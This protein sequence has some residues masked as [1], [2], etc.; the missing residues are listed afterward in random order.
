[1]RRLLLCLLVAVLAVSTAPAAHA[2]VPP[3]TPTYQLGWGSTGTAPGQFDSPWGG[4][5]DSLGNVYIVDRHNLRVEKFNS[6]GDFVMSLNGMALPL[7]VAVSNGVVYVADNSWIKEFDS[8]GN[9]ILQFGSPGSGNGQFSFA[10]GIAV[11]R[12]G[13]MYVADYYLMRV[14]KFTAGGGYVSQW[15]SAGSGNGQFNN[16]TG[17]CCDAS[18][19]VYVVDQSNHRVQEFTSS[20]VYVT[21]WGTHGSANGQFAF[22]SGIAVDALGN[23]YVTDEGNG[24]VQKF[25]PS[26]AYVTQF[27]SV[28]SANG[29]FVTPAG[30]AVDPAG[31]V[32]VSDTGNDRLQK[33][34][35]A[36]VGLPTVHWRDWP[37][38]S[39]NYS[40]PSCAM[41]AASNLYVF[42]YSGIRKY[43]FSGLNSSLIWQKNTYDIPLDPNP[44]PFYD[45]AGIAV[46]RSGNIYVTE[47]GTQGAPVVKFD[48]A[49]NYVARW[50]SWGS[51]NGEFSFPSGIAADGSGNVYVVDQYQRRVQKFSSDGTYLLQ[52]GTMGS[53]NG[54]FDSPMGIATD[55]GGNVYVG[56]PHLNTTRQGSIQ[57]FSAAGTYVGQWPADGSAL[58]IDALG[59]VFSNGAVYTTNGVQMG[60]WDDPAAPLCVTSDP[61][62]NVYFV[63]QRDAHVHTLWPARTI[64]LVSDVG[65]DQGHQARVRFPR[66]IYDNAAAW[67]KAYDVYSVLDTSTAVGSVQNTGYVGTFVAI[68]VSST[69]NAT[70]SSPSYSGY[71]VRMRTFGGS[72]VDSDVGY[73]YS[74]DN[75]PPPIPSPFTGVYA[76]GAVH[77]H[78]AAS[79]AAD[80]SVFKLYRGTNSSFVPGPG[81]LIATQ[82]D[83]AYADVGQAIGYYKLSAVDSSGNESGFATLGLTETSSVGGP[84]SV[85]FALYGLVANPSRA[86]ALRIAFSLDDRAEAELALY[87]VTGRRI[88]VREVGCLGAGPHTLDLTDG[89]RLAPGVYEIRLRRGGVSKRAKAVVLR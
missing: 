88:A 43:Q 4:A 34:S 73:G 81:N 9:L 41:D 45:P 30:V 75:L 10:S 24:R 82:P 79:L 80:F 72:Y 33:Y 76:S 19:N 7:F 61:T 63:S 14:Q 17:M 49:G 47:R 3:L 56:D 23:F 5:C 69:T 77:L 78:W 68:D 85:S 46:D 38:L 20:G 66:H 28:G 57:K 62:G 60:S 8:D 25:S 22:P 86:D 58:A 6:R 70:A 1:M 55:V 27:G 12:S 52:W 36:G 32:Y 74:V 11:D 18:G 50:G 39:G 71:F 21:Q 40:Y 65:N 87:D 31:N 35:G 42:D 44:N 13:N 15:G 84:H 37:V 26:F 53:G 51:G 89:T 48:A 67:V 16:P 29:Q 2:L 59:D 83:T 54:Q 64:T